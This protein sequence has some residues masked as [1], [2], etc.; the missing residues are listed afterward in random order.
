MLSSAKEVN[1]SMFFLSGST[2]FCRFL[3]LPR[4]GLV[5]YRN[6]IELESNLASDGDKDCLSNARKLYEAALA[7]YNQNLSLWQDYYS[8]EIKVILTLRLIQNIIVLRM[9]HFFKLYK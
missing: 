1:A 6:C 3:A 4:P 8:M 5:F 2:L 9:Y 7:T